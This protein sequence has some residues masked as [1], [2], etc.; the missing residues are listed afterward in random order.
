MA[1]S[2]TAAAVEPAMDVDSAMSQATIGGLL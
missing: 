2:L 1:G